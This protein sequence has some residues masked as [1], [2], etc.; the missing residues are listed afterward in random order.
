MNGQVAT[1]KEGEGW[2]INEALRAVGVVR[3][4]DE[5]EFDTVCL[6]KYRSMRHFE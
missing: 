4:P 2:P 1:A 6:D 5:D 3:A